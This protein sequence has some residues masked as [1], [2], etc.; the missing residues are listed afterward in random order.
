VSWEIRH[1]DCTEAMREMD[2]ASVDAIVCDP[3]YGMRFMGKT[4]ER[5]TLELTRREA[6]LIERELA[7]WVD[8]Q[9]GRTKWEVDDARRLVVRIRTALNQKDEK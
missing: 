5:V 8:A 3:P 2:E 6:R 7:F 1:A 9:E 4:W